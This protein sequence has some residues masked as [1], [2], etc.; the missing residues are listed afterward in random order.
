M[1][2]QTAP[3]PAPAEVI[4][5]GLV[6][7]TFPVSALLVDGTFPD[8]RRVVP[9]L[10]GVLLGSRATHI[11]S[12][13]DDAPKGRPVTYLGV[14]TALLKGMTRAGEPCATFDWNGDG[15]LLVAT[16]D[17]RFLG[18]VMPMSGGL[19]PDDMAARRAAVLG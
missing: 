1:P 11:A 14:D 19:S 8:W 7:Q 13:H 15:P 3:A 17:P 9:S 10:D 2:S 6:T 18:V 5:G 16:Q 4:D 12:P